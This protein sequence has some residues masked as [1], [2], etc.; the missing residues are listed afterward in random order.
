[1]EVG[2]IR[3]DLAGKPLPRSATH[4]VRTS[5]SE[6]GGVR[7]LTVEPPERRTDV[8]ILYLHGGS[9]LFGSPETH[10]DIASRFALAAG[11]RVVLPDYR[12]AP[13]HPFPAQ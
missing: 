3:A 10:L 5:E 8:V 12:L 13:E 7:A 9:Y 1:M 11:A 2:A 6:L 4:R